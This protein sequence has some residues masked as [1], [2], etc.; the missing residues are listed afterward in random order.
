[1]GIKEGS[2]E[3]RLSKPL[4][5]SMGGNRAEAEMVQLFEPTMEHSQY[6]LKLKQLL[7]RS[8]MDLAKQIENLDELRDSLGQQVKPFH[9]DV[10]KLES[11]NDQMFEAFDAALNAS[12]SVD[13]SMFQKQFEKMILKPAKKPIAK[14]DGR[15]VMTSV[16]WSNLHPD[17]AWNMAVRWCVFF[18]MPSLEGTKKSSEQQSDS[19]TERMEA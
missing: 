2:F 17:D 5:Y 18:A 6:Y 8:Q 1:M 11:E 13:V 7:T 19:V 14:V 16:L 12:E 9:E 10:D 4:E 3:F 15:V